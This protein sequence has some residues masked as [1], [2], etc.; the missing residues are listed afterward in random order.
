LNP[1]LDAGARATRSASW[2]AASGIVGVYA[3]LY[4]KILSTMGIRKSLY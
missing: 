4:R 2:R 1:G 3:P